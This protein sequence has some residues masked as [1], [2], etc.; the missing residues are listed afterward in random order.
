MILKIFTNTLMNAYIPD[1]I[2][3]LEKSRIPTETEVF[4]SPMFD[5]FDISWKFIQKVAYFDLTQGSL[6]ENSLF[7]RPTNVY[8]KNN[9]KQLFKNYN[10]LKRW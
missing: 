5:L 9:P 6:T 1:L 2:T 10:C 8:V 3:W 4:Q 7:I